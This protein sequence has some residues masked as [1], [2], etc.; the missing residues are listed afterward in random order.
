MEKMFRWKNLKGFNN[1]N[2]D[3]LQFSFSAHLSY[4]IVVYWQSSLF[5]INLQNTRR[6]LM[7][8]ITRRSE[9]SIFIGDDIKITILGTKN[10]QTRVG[11]DAP[12]N[13]PI[14]REEIRQKIQRKKKAEEKEYVEEEE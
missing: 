13:I 4:G 8:V 1:N 6:N 9:E 11:I 7:L 12:K 2:K 3:S 10:G 5:V 14:Y